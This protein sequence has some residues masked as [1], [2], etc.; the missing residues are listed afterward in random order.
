MRA[1]YTNSLSLQTNP[2]E[3]RR[4]NGSNFNCR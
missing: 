3:I 4:T 1:E 2:A